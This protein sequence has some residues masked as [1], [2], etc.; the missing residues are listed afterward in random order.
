[1]L[2]KISTGTNPLPPPHGLLK[3]LCLY[4]R[5]QKAFT[6]TSKYTAFMQEN[7]ELPLFSIGFTSRTDAGFHFRCSKQTCAVRSGQF[8]LCPCPWDAGSTWRAG[9][10]DLGG[11]WALQRGIIQ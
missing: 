10:A 11:T 3:K 9:D 7:I 5:K 2:R 1:M 6:S 4:F 8:R